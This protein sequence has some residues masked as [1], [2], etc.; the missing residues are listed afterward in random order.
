MPAPVSIQARITVAFFHHLRLCLQLRDNGL[1][2]LVRLGDGSPASL[3]LAVPADQE[4][5]KVPLDALEAHQT[6]LLRFEPLEEGVGAV[7]VDL[8]LLHNGEGDAIVDLAKAL[9]FLIACGPS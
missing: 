1:L 3:D 5:L 2:Q 6:R 8:D 4:L 7:S 9:N